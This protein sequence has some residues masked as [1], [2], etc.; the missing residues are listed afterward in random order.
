MDTPVIDQLS[1][2]IRVIDPQHPLFGQFFELCRDSRRRPG[3][4]RIILTDGR[5][6]WV[7]QAATD[8]HKDACE[9]GA[10]H[11]VPYVSARTLIPLAQYVGLLLSTQAKE[12]R[13]PH[14]HAV[15]LATRAGSC[16][17]LDTSGAQTV[18]IDGHDRAAAV[19]AANSST[20]STGVDIRR[21][22]PRAKRG[23]PR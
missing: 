10:N 4:L 17:P 15:G 22:H 5:P 7:R 13:G 14:V 9:A 1:H 2:K 16:R 23:K 21:Q 12:E 20:G 3:W 18:A 6:R 8:L 19:G 11:D